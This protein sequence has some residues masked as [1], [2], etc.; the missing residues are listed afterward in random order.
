MSNLKFTIIPLTL[1]IIMFFAMG[2][3][4]EP[5]TC[6]KNEIKVELLLY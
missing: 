1:R 6:N 3:F 5:Y 4:P 2:Y